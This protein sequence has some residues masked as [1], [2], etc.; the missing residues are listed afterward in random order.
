MFPAFL[1]VLTIVVFFAPL[2]L[3]AAAWIWTVAN[4]GAL[5]WRKRLFV[6]G[7]FPLHHGVR[8]RQTAALVGFWDVPECQEAGLAI[9][10]DGGRQ[11]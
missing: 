6:L 4:G 2:A 11:L 7:V 3:L 10:W 8:Q 1:T 9:A 5:P